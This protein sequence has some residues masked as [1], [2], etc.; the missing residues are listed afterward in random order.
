MGGGGGG[1]GYYGR[2]SDSEIQQQISDTTERLAHGY[3]PDLQQTLDNLL[4]EINDRDVG[5]VNLLRSEIKNAIAGELGTPV[6]NLSFG[7]SV[8]KNTFVN[9]L[10]DVDALAIFRHMRANDAL[11]AEIKEKIGD[12]ISKAL[13]DASVSVGRVAV[14]AKFPDGLELQVIP[15]VRD[16]ANLRVPSWDGES[17]S[18]INPRKFTRALSRHNDRLGGKLIPT[19]KL[20]KRVI[21]ELPEQH[22]ISGYH[23]EALAISAFRRYEGENMTARMLPLFFKRASQLV[24]EPIRD[25]SGQSVYVDEYLGRKRSADRKAVSHLF[26]RLAKR[27]QNASAA[28][29]VGRW[30]EILGLGD[31]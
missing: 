1:G 24:L 30:A 23:V 29:S 20:A 14:T 15:A 21:A 28:K 10:S 3:E 25:S 31:E 27:M 19:I 5:R 22:Q 8:S 12:A 17:W 4:P 7:G 18:K 9:G 26:D 2:V 16:G 11:P 13:P 6:I